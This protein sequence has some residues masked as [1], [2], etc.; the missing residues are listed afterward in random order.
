M[1]A[2][3]N[4]AA[5]QKSFEVFQTRRVTTVQAVRFAPGAQGVAAWRSSVQRSCPRR[6]G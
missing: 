5:I 6:S 2:V 3:P 4:Y 1:S